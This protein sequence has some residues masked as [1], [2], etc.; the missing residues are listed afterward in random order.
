MA[1][2]HK[3][4]RD[5]TEDAV[6][7]RQI[8]FNMYR[9]KLI[10]IA[11]SM[12]DWEVPDTIDKQFLEKTLTFKGRI[13][14]FKD[15]DLG[16]LAL[17]MRNS[18]GL[19]IYGKPLNRVA[20]AN[21]GYQFG[22]SGDTILDETNSVVIYNNMLRENSIMDI[23]YYADK[24]AEIDQVISI[25]LNAQKFP[26][27]ISC[28]KDMQVAMLNLYEQYESGAPVIFGDDRI[29]TAAGKIG[30]INTTAPFVVDKLQIQKDNLWNEA[31]TA[32][33]VPNVQINKKERLITD[34]V[35]RAQG[36]INACRYS[37]QVSREDG[38]ERCKIV[39]PDQKWGV[40]FREESVQETDQD[41]MNQEVEND[42]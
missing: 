28:T 4:F 21:N 39:F 10:N 24:L 38:A 30:A 12:W 14:I 8:T 15:P 18:K 26:I 22:N 3:R 16:Y 20:Y 29:Q 27:L 42:G 11:L 7:N 40:K 32:L 5:R 23:E 6:I 13:L 1:K 31:M 36:G 33:G 37:R 19:D 17:P 9:R 2:T 35:N 41:K 34:E 25:N